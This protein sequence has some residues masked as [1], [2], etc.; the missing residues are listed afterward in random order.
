MFFVCYQE[1][2]LSFYSEKAVNFFFKGNM[3]H[4]SF[5]VNLQ[6]ITLINLYYILKNIIRNENELKINKIF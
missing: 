4:N 3:Y 6:I 1:T 2:S 5:V